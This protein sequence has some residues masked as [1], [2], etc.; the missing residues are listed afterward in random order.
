MTPKELESHV[1][2]KCIDFLK[3]A[4]KYKTDGF[5]NSDPQER[6]KARVIMPDKLYELFSQSEIK[7]LKGVNHE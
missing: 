5:Q 1:R 6:E 4:V 3:F 2:G 7:I